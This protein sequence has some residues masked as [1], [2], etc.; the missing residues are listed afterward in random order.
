[1]AIV[2]EI[3]T[4]FSFLGSLTPQR[5]FNENLT[6]SIKLMSGMVAGL[7]A[8]G[9][10]MFGWAHSVFAGIDPLVQLSRETGVAVQ[11]MSELGYVASVN[12]SNLDA[13]KSSMI[14]LTKRMGEFE[15]TGTG[16]AAES[17]KLL[18]LNFR[19][20]SGKMKT[21]DM[22]MLD[23]QDKMRGL[24]NAEKISFM[25][26]LGIDRSLLQMM[27]LTG[28]Q[29]DKLRERARK[30]GTVTQDQG[31]NVADYN[32][33]LTTLRY[34][35]SAVQKTVA[36]GFAPAMTRLVESFTDLL[37]ANKDWIVNGLIRLGKVTAGVIDMLR[38]MWPAITAIGVA[39]GIS[40]I[41]AFGFIKALGIIFSP[42]VL[43][44]AAIAAV[45]LIVDDLIVAFRGGQ[46]VIKDFFDSFGIDIVGI[47]RPVVNAI[48][49]AFDDMILIFSPLID[50]IKS[51]FSA[52]ISAFTG[53]WG[54]ALDHLSDAFSSWIDF[55][56]GLFSSLLSGIS[57]M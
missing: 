28:E 53:D 8:A 31:N 34:G 45:I 16:R 23:L 54:G 30:F 47:L 27:N 57:T 51:L 6:S 29:I 42:V 25:N 39:F 50:S 4:K 35:L 55:V 56:R 41:A 46:S 22:V 20:A 3:V 21:A 36:V 44:T 9:A 48:S 15:N 40:K 10:A 38:R 13:V 49:T 19:D 7:G 43:I 2:N 18:G 26:K 37:A 32:D 24:S 11:A 5:T 33:A 14:E 17:I 12:G 52:V 1:M